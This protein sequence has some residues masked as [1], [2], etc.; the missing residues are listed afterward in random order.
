M[1]LT[2]VDGKG[3]KYS[4][5]KMCPARAVSIFRILM[6]RRLACRWGSDGDT[7]CT[8]G[9][10]VFEETFFA[11]SQL[12]QIGLVE[13]FL[14]TETEGDVIMTQ[15]SF[16]RKE[17]HLLR[18]K[19]KI[20]KK[21][22]NTYISCVENYQTIIKKILVSSDTTFKIHTKSCNADTVETTSYRS[23]TLAAGP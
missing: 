11:L 8:N 4:G 15:L 7:G 3:C 1:G 9:L 16:R 10:F 18:N 13:Q 20:I 6:G 19:I 2:G 12:S 21:V 22:N 5:C 23:T 14:S 17:T